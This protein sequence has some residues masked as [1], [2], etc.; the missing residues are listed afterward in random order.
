MF[1]FN[2]LIYFLSNL[3]RQPGNFFFFCLATILVTFTQS[4]IFR[5]L[6]CMTRTPEQAMVPTA[7]L[8]L[9]LLV[10]PGFTVP[11]DY[12]PGW[13]RWMN[14]INPIAYAFEALMVNEFHGREFPC[15][16][17]VPAGEGY[18]NLSP[19]NQICSVVGASRGS[20][21]V[22]GDRYINS[23]FKYYESHK[24]RYVTAKPH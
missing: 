11:T 2:L 7:L 8:T 21:I 20:S 23:A 19:E 3:N 15:A 24:W 17:M 16:T 14:Y 22:D 1:V 6:A 4:A 9:G 13:S 5:T 10:Y 18:D 12:M